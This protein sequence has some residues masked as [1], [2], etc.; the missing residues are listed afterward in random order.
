MTRAW[1]PRHE[2]SQEK[3]SLSW[4][5]RE[6]LES[7]CFLHLETPTSMKAVIAVLR[8]YPNQMVLLPKEQGSPSWHAGVSQV[9]L[10]HL[11]SV[12]IISAPF[13]CSIVAKRHHDHGNS[14]KRI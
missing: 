1:T 14:N 3:F 8:D 6:G 2:V 7:L 12:T 9:M 4:W 10:K 5:F 13:K 11:L